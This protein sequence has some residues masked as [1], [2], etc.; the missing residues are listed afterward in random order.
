MFLSW[1]GYLIF[2]PF[3]LILWCKRLNLWDIAAGLILVREA[4]GICLNDKGNDFDAIEDNSL[5]ASSAAI[6]SELLKNL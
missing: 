4:G 2:L 3:F 6:S 1:T 5:I